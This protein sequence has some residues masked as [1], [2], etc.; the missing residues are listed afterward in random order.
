MKVVSDPTFLGD[1]IECARETSTSRYAVVARQARARDRSR[2]GK[3]L[4]TV[5]Q[6]AMYVGPSAR[7]QW[8]AHVALRRRCWSSFRCRSISRRLRDFTVRCWRDSRRRRV[9]PDAFSSLHP[10]DGAGIRGGKSTRLPCRMTVDTS[11]DGRMRL[12]A[13]LTAPVTSLC[14]CSKNILDY[15]AHN[16]R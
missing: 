12:I 16:N 6:F 4:H 10:Q 15:G 1:R 5:A 2:T 14:P 9:A 3:L 11:A 8:H 7:R 13:E